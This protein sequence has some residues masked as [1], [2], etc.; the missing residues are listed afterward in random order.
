[1]D[2]K[3]IDRAGTSHL[4][5]VEKEEKEKPKQ[6]NDGNYG[7]FRGQGWHVAGRERSKDGIRESLS[8]TR[9][10]ETQRESNQLSHQ[11]PTH[12]EYAKIGAVNGG[13]LEWIRGDKQ[14]D[15]GADWHHRDPTIHLL[16]QG[17]LS[18][19]WEKP[20]YEECQWNNHA[21][22]LGQVHS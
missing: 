21:R 3:K 22:V 17:I 16:V 8:S 1:M 7:W 2:Y 5:R 6:S 13:G 4:L 9:V 18:W 11:R 12:S 20:Q 15:D 19:K 14:K 10:I